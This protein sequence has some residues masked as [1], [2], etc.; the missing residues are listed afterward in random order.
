MFQM[1]IRKCHVNCLDKWT[2]D[3]FIPEI[4]PQCEHQYRLNESGSG[5]GKLNSWDL[6]EQ[7]FM[8]SP[9]FCQ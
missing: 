7:L 1:K 5:V 9:H 6:F 2:N 3:L 8:N 4:L